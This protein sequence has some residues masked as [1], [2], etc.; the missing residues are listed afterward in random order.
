M[1]QSALIVLAAL[2]L[3]L[4]LHLLLP[5]PHPPFP[6]R[7]QCRS[8][9][10][11]QYALASALGDAQALLPLT[12]DHPAWPAGYPPDHLPARAGAEGMDAVKIFIGIFTVA[13]AWSRRQLIR[14]TYRRQAV[15]GVKWVFVLGRAEGNEVEEE[16]A[17]KSPLVPSSGV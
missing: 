6:W 3:A 4:L 7:D 8:S 15:E 13:G 5:G 16:A 12:P 10:P 9:F 1:I 2:L 14:E 11:T 17:R